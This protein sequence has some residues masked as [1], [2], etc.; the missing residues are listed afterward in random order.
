M[1]DRRCSESRMDGVIIRAIR[2]PFFFSPFC[3]TVA[4]LGK[5][6]KKEGLFN[7]HK[8]LYAFKGYECFFSVGKDRVNEVIIKL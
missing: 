1:H 4:S 5:Y 6:L 2:I 3:S 7:N 8:L